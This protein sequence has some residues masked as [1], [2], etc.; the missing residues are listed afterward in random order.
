MFFTPE[1]ELL[2]IFATFTFFRQCF[3]GFCFEIKKNTTIYL[4]M[5]AG[6]SRKLRAA[7]VPIISDVECRAP[8]VYGET[9]TTGMF[10]AGEL[11]GGTDSCQGDS[12][13]PFVCENNGELDHVDHNVFGLYSSLCPRKDTDHWHFWCQGVPGRGNILSARTRSWEKRNIAT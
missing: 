1:L 12:G 10:C 3:N 2:Q 6:Y 13:G 5:V 4:T 8:Y 7:A 11:Q 9:L